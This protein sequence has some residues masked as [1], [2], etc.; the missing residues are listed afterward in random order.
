MVE[1]FDKEKK[2]E[3]FRVMLKNIESDYER[4]LYKYFYLYYAPLYERI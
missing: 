1:L 2:L 3:N 4:F